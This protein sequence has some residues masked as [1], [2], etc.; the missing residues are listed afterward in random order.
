MTCL[1]ELCV[2]RSTSI[3]YRSTGSHGD[4]VIDFLWPG[5]CLVFV[6]W[7]VVISMFISLEKLVLLDFHLTAELSRL[8]GCPC[9]VTAHNNTHV[10][11]L[12]ERSQ[13]FL[14][15]FFI[16][17]LLFL[18]NIF[19]IWLTNVVVYSSQCLG[20]TSQINGVIRREFTTTD[21]TNRDYIMT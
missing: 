2:C 11:Y 16:D 14:L 9:V 6:S 20:T 8:V 15:I 5:Y 3:H 10:N 21:W 18:H 1:L 4:Q 7:S 19:L 12:P 17:C 13:Y